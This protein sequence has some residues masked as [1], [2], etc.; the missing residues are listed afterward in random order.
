[1]KKSVFSFMLASIILMGAI[2]CTSTFEVEAASAHEKVVIVIDPGHGGTGEKNLG[3]QYNGFSEKELTMQVATAMKEELEKYDNVSV[4]LTRTTDTFIS[5]ED[6]AATAKRLNADFMF[7]IHFN[8]SLEHEFYGSEIWTSA[9]GS[10]YK[11]GAE[12]GQ[13]MSD[14]LGNLGLY[15]RGVK[16]KI[17]KTGKDYYGII[18]QSVARDIPCVIIE[19]AYLDHSYDLPFLNTAGFLKTLGVTDATAVAKYFKLTSK[20]TGADYS[21]YSFKTVSIPK[22]RLS[23]DFTE[24]D[25]CKV[26]CVS[27]D[28]NSRNALIE[29]STKDS[30]SPVIY[31]SY[32]YDGGKTFSIL[33]MWDRT[34]ET[35]SFNI[36]IPKGVVSPTIVCR[37]YNNYELYKE[38]EPVLVTGYT[39]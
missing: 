31:F 25:Y 24:P 14:E 22:T 39:N 3:A 9:F 29:M 15:Q 7:S 34:K 27:Y 1:M 16:T 35:Q 6:R 8:A 11:K 4:Y 28:S 37:A 30:Q 10:F 36:K 21:N 12:F 32:S 17:G 18:R 26:S 5:L 33:Q 2:L 38:S 13:I 19:H 23:Q 20:T